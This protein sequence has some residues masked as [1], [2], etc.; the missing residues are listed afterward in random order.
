VALKITTE[1][2]SKQDITRVHRELRNY[3][4]IITQSALR[5]DNPIKYPS[6]SDNLRGI[7][8]ENKID[9]KQEK[10]CQR[11]LSELESIAKHAPVVHISFSNDP[12]PEMLY[13][14]IQWFRDKINPN[15]FIQVG[16]QPTIA[17]GV[18]IRTPNKHFDFSIRR[19]LY[20]NKSKLAEALKA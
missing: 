16:V 15:I 20:N 17:A 3:L 19:H 14:L 9:L 6:I 7:V 18:V 10:E 1:I 11:L 4:D 5:H 12:E 2:T 13:K 8:I